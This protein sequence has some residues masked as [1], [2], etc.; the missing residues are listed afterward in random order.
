MSTAVQ[1]KSLTGRQRDVISH[2]RAR[3]AA[4]R[5]INSH[6]DV[7]G[8]DR[9]QVSIPVGLDDDDIVILDYIQQQMRSD[10]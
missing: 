6:Y 9:P 4:V 1:S 5:L 8:S 2:E 10:L 3:I 7:E